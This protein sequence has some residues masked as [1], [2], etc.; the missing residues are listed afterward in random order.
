MLPLAAVSLM[1]AC[2]DLVPTMPFDMAMAIISG[3]AFVIVLAI[4]SDEG[5]K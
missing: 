2:H 1:H 3:I 5:R 4:L